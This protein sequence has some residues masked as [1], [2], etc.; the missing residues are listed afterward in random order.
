MR[1]V[2]VLFGVTVCVSTVV[3]SAGASCG[4][5]TNEAFVDMTDGD[6][7][8]VTL[9]EQ[10][11]ITISQSATSTVKAWSVTSV[12][13][14][15]TCVATV[16]FS[17]SAKPPPYPPVPLH[18]RVLQSTVGTLLLEWT[19]PSGTLKPPDY[20][21]NVW[22][23]E[24][25]LPAAEACRLFNATPYQDLHDGD[26]K[27]VQ[28]ALAPASDSLVLT[29]S[30][31]GIWN[32]TTPM[33]PKTCKATVDFSKSTKPKYPPVPLVVS[34]SVASGSDQRDR[35]M[36]TFTDP[37]ATISPAPGFPLNIW[38]GIYAPGGV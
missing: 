37:T 12:L 2:G 27:Y 33:D 1:S 3:A 11:E 38:E 8:N 15:T 31:P 7:K 20:P 16:D 35:I 19:D 25:A 29:M 6:T 32:L 22:T 28:L 18:A 4:S 5:T 9:T 14:L 24:D 17:K 13:D 26:I 36:L 23:T 34:V 30:Q 10:G 21:L